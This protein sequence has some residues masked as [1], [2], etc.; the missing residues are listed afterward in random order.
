MPLATTDDP[1]GRGRKVLDNTL[2][3]VMS[4]IGDGRITRASARS[5]TRRPRRSC[6]WSPSARPA[7]RAEERPVV[8][9]PSRLKDIGGQVNRPLADIYLTMAKRW[10][11]ERHFPGRRR[12]PGC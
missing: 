12:L 11:G 10:G 9:F 5:S 4:E 2:I 6:R 1:G 8:Q 3:Y 7:G